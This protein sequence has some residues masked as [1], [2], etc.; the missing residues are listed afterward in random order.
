MLGAQEEGCDEDLIVS[1]CLTGT[2]GSEMIYS[3]GIV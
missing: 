2:W 3:G 1:S